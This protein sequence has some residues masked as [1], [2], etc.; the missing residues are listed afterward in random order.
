MTTPSF[1]KKAGNSQ[2][3]YSETDH[4]PLTKIKA[5]KSKK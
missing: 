4:K 3:T 5:T 1:K 2:K